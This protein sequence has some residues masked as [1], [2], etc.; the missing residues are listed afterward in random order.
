MKENNPKVENE[1]WGRVRCREGFIVPVS[2][3]YFTSGVFI[4]R[5]CVEKKAHEM[6][7]LQSVNS[8]L[9]LQ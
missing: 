9:Q 3:P 5:L 7:P 8:Q 6:R 4:M 1:V 2:K